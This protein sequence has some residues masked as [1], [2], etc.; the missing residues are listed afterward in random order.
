MDNKDLLLVFLLIALGTT[1][2]LLLRKQSSS[3]LE[4]I[5]VEKDE[6]GRVVGV[7][8]HRKVKYG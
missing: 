7:V 1:I 5:K 4:E 3:N 6:R 8:V 2:V